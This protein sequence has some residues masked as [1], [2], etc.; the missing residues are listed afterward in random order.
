MSD[1][2]GVMLVACPGDL[3]HELGASGGPTLDRP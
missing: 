2:S 1:K 3:G